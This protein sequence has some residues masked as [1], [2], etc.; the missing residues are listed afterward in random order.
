MCFSVAS[1]LLLFSRQ[2]VIASILVRSMSLEDA[3]AVLADHCDGQGRPIPHLERFHDYA[4]LQDLAA[5]AAARRSRPIP[6]PTPPPR[7]RP[8]ATAEAAPAKA[9]IC[10]QEMCFLALLW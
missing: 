8:P 4:W 5:R 2:A 1:F 6:P 9:P 7:R 3:K 10:C